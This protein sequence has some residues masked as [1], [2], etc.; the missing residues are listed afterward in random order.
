MFNIVLMA[1]TLAK[2]AVVGWCQ[3]QDGLEHEKE[4]KEH[5][6]EEEVV[7]QVGYGEENGAFFLTTVIKPV[8]IRYVDRFPAKQRFVGVCTHW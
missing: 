5:C 3:S 4:S 1:D 6:C 7:G 2:Q 8:H